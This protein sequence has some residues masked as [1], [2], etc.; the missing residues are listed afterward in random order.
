MDLRMEKTMR[1]RLGQ[2]LSLYYRLKLR[3]VM[4]QIASEVSETVWPDVMRKKPNCSS[5]EL[6][7]YTRV[8]A[9]QLVHPRIDGLLKQHPRVNGAFGSQLVASATTSVEKLIKQK[10]ARVSDS[11]RSQ[12]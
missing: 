7:E 12:A 3:K 8:R 9:G 4:R 6:N 5:K 1:K 10:L 11:A 2:P